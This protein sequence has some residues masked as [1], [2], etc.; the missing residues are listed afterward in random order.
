MRIQEILEKVITR[1]AQEKADELGIEFK[2]KHSVKKG[3]DTILVRIK[4][5]IPE[6]AEGLTDVEIQS[7]KEVIDKQNLFADYISGLIVP[8]YLNVVRFTYPSKL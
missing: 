1:K 5:D 3:M 2:V 7:Y 6:S 8:T 4:R